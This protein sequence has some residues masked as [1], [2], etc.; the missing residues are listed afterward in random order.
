MTTGIGGCAQCR[1]VNALPVSRLSVS[2]PSWQVKSMIAEYL[3]VYT[4]H[5]YRNKQ[6]Y[7]DHGAN[8]DNRSTPVGTPPLGG[9]VHCSLS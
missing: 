2:S 3:R 8:R 6:N 4:P 7:R 5:N 9:T 1:A